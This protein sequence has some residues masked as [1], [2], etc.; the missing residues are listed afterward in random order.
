M[1]VKFSQIIVANSGQ[2]NVENNIVLSSEDTMINNA[3]GEM[4][5][6]IAILLKDMYA[7]GM[8]TIIMIIKHV[9][10]IVVDRSRINQVFGINKHCNHV[11]LRIKD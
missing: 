11:Q 7:I 3:I 6:N 4:A 9:F 2:F 5:D 1:N 8:T 10:K